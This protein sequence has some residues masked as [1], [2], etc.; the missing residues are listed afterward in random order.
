MDY[1]TMEDRHQEAVHA[2]AETYE[3]AL[4][5]VTAEIR[6]GFVG[7]FCGKPAMTVPTLVFVGGSDQ[8][9]LQPVRDA[10][11]ESLD[12]D[13]T[14]NAL[15][16]MLCGQLPVERFRELLIERYIASNADDIVW[17]RTGLTV[18]RK[19]AMRALGDAL[20]APFPAFLTREAA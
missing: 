1:E 12:Y 14:D 13:D 7:H 18:P 2:A 3:S 10:I 11:N 5:S 15:H 20:A 8:V 6:A 4:A 16:C 17:A 19:S 9:S